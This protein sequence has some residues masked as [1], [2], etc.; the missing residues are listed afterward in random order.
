MA[1][2]HGLSWKDA[3]SKVRRNVVEQENQRELERR[4]EQERNESDLR[5]RLKVDTAE[6]LNARTQAIRADF[7]QAVR[8]FCPIGDLD[9]VREAQQNLHDLLRFYESCF[10]RF[11]QVFSAR[12]KSD[13]PRLRKELE[14]LRRLLN[15]QDRQWKAIAEVLEEVSFVPRTPEH[16]EALLIVARDFSQRAHG[17][18][19]SIPADYFVH[20]SENF[21]VVETTEHV[22]GYVKLVEE[23]GAR[24]LVFALSPVGKMNFNKYVRGILYKFATEGPPPEKLSAIRVRVTYQREVKFY[25]EL[26]FTRTEIKGP[27]DWIYERPV[28]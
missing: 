8:K 3:L 24:R 7:D 22:L 6:S 21:W 12:H 10:K 17:I 25:T 13:I 9:K 15:R 23:D 11:G 14:E 4:L 20:E 19:L 5:E 26:G 2:D 18:E 16:D 1:D 28:E 27:S